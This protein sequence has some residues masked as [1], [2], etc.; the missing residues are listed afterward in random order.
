MGKKSGWWRSLT[1]SMPEKP[2]KFS[3]SFGGD[4]GPLGAGG[5]AWLVLLPTLL[6]S[7]DQVP[8]AGLGGARPTG[9]G[10]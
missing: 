10:G 6:L 5:A 9:G 3:A 2:E 4:F 1:Y 7:P 8:Q